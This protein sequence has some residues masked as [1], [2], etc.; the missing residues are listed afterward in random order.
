MSRKFTPFFRFVR[1]SLLA[2]A[3]DFGLGFWLAG[4]GL[5]TLVWATV[6]GT[7]LGVAVGF[8]LNKLWTF[9]DKSPET[10][11]QFM[12]YTLVAFGNLG[13]NALGVGLLERAGLES[14]WLI[15]IIVG[16]AVFVG[17]SYVVTK[18]FVFSGDKAKTTVQI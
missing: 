15:R 10:A 16:T 17:Y 7:L 12:R 18:A 4:N 5:A 1:V 14:Y 2:T 13:L 8:I 11:S 6:W 9:H 3:L